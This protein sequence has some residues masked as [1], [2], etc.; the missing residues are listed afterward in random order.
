MVALPFPLLL[1][2]PAIGVDLL[3]KRTADVHGSLRLA[4]ISLAFGAVFLAV[5]AVVQWHFAKFL[6]SPHAQNW[7]FMSDRIWS[8]SSRPGEW[9]M[10]FWSD[11]PR[12]GAPATLSVAAITLSWVIA[13]FSSGVGIFFGRWM[14]KVRR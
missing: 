8:Y 9:R 11:R 13:S 5:L 14:R 3:V 12:S 1:I 10:Q 2:F 4:G 7:F 6:L